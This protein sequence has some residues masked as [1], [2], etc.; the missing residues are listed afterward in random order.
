[1]RIFVA[2]PG[3]LQIAESPPGVEEAWDL[4]YADGVPAGTAA[5][6]AMAAARSGRDPVAWAQHFVGLRKVLRS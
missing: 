6:L 4:M 3:G 2:F 5:E 1:M